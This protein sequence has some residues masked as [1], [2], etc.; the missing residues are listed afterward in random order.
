MKELR[1]TF[2]Y[3]AI[4]SNET[5]EEEIRKKEACERRLKNQH[6]WMFDELDGT[7]EF[8]N[9]TGCFSVMIAYVFDKQPLIS[10][11]YLPAKDKLY[12]AILGSRVRV[13]E[14]GNERELTISNPRSLENAVILFGRK[15]FSEEKAREACNK[16]GAKELRQSE[17]FGFNVGLMAENQADLWVHNDRNIPES[18]VCA[19]GIIL[20]GAGGTVTDYDGQ[21]ITYNNS[22]P[23]LKNGVV[24]GNGLIHPRV[25]PLI[26]SYLPLPVS[27]LEDMLQG[28]QKA[29]ELRKKAN[30]LKQTA[31]GLKLFSDI[32][33]FFNEAVPGNLG[34]RIFYCLRKHSVDFT[35]AEAVKMMRYAK[36]RIEE[37]TKV[38][39]KIEFL[40]FD[41]DRLPEY[42]AR[43]KH[44]HQADDSKIVPMFLDFCCFKNVDQKLSGLNECYDRFS[45]GA[46][47]YLALPDKYKDL[48][49]LRDGKFDESW[50]KFRKRLRADVKP[51]DKEELGWIN[52]C[53]DAEKRTKINLSDII[54]VV[55]HY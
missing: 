6:L 25:L 20:S 14:N 7:S 24:F 19:P 10:V 40:D 32:I 37:H 9:H 11:V 16:F 39:K 49:A 26:G 15:R 18:S 12:T 33:T 35:Q 29:D 38:R 3:H 31:Q 54:K 8:I 41:I 43:L 50:D 47:F 52:K 34:D 45:K 23:Y 44:I 42:V 4:L 36:L 48:P 30:K 46:E 53:E 5:F 13:S 27:D 1:D 2:P 22:W 17:S 51:E 28:L 21:M 55:H